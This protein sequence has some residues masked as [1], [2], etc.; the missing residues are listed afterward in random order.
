M[1]DQ[2]VCTSS[3]HPDQFLDGKVEHLEFLPSK[4][5]QGWD[6]QHRNTICN[7]SFKKKKTIIES[8]KAQERN[9]CSF[10][11]R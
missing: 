1:L 8:E 7:E 6:F 2:K 10:V 9:D 11:V 5:V 3:F 4:S